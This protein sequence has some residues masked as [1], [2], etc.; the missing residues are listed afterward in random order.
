MKEIVRSLLYF[1]WAGLFEIGGG[2][3]VWQWLKEGKP[4]FWGILGGI[5]LALYGIVA[6]FQT[7]GFGRTYAAYGGIFVAM[8]MIW[9]WKVDGVKPDNYD[10]LGAF[11]AMIGVFIIMYA[12]R[13]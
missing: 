8:A 2:Y 13:S 3:L 1:M 6:T 11:V 10:F 7:S 4:L 5:I 9:G 12:P